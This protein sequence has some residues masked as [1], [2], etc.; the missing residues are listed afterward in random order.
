[1]TEETTFC[2]RVGKDRYRGPQ[3]GNIKSVYF[4]CSLLSVP[5]WVGV[6]L[7]PHWFPPPSSSSLQL[8]AGDTRSK[9]PS[10]FPIDSVS[11]TLKRLVQAA[12]QW[13]EGQYLLWWKYQERTHHH[14]IDC[15]SLLSKVNILK[16]LFSDSWIFYSGCGIF[17]LTLC[18]FMSIFVPIRP[19]NRAWIFFGERFRSFSYTVCETFFLPGSSWK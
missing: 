9:S 5:S 1:M 6:L 19:L 18:P 16:F 17:G 11:I 10:Y 14:L 13:Y 8:L 7:S 2:L 12:I 3:R 4:Q 15:R